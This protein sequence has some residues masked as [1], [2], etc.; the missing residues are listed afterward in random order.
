MKALTM[1]EL[2]AKAIAEYK[3]LDVKEQSAVIGAVSNLSRIEQPNEQQILEFANR[4]GHRDLALA[5][6]GMYLMGVISLLWESED[7]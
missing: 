3:A 1:D 7:E 6:Y 5:C 2:F 4:S